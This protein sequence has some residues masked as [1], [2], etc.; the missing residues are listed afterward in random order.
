MM[1]HA[2]GAPGAGMTF[3]TIGGGN[4]QQW[5]PQI[6]QGEMATERVLAVDSIRAGVDE[7]NKFLY[8]VLDQLRGCINS[9]LG[10]GPQESSG[11]DKNTTPTAS[12][13]LPGLAQSVANTEQLARALMAQVERLRSI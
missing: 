10:G 7:N 4:P 1:N 12:G 3:G 9:L 13:R 2:A 5:V 6:P 11:G 8:N